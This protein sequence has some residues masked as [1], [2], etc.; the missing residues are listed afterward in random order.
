[1]IFFLAA[2]TFILSYGLYVSVKK[3][4]ELQEQLETIDLQ[5]EECLDVLEECHQ[6]IEAKSKIEVFSD[7]P[8]VKELI[9]DIKEAKASVL[10]VAKNLYVT[11]NNDETK[12]S[13]Q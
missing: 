10:L 12:A 3:N 2:I 6:K 1:M 7:E 8:V 9:Q 5:I 4:L 11:E 13:E